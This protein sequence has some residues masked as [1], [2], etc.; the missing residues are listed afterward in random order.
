MTH[1]TVFQLFI[2]SCVTLI[3]PVS[4]ELLEKTCS[5][6]GGGSLYVSQVI[7]EADAPEIGAPIFSDVADGRRVEKT[8]CEPHGVIQ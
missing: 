3:A 7:C 8:K 2:Y 6:S 5:W 4:G 1:I